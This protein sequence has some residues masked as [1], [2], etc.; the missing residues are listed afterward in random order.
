M[1]ICGGFA[2][3]IPTADLYEFDFGTLSVCPDKN[4]LSK[5]KKQSFL[6]NQQKYKE[7]V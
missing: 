4:F 6:K 3:S 5:S 1:Y 2:A 7:N